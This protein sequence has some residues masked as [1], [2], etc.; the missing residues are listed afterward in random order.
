MF[1]KRYEHLA[2]LDPPYLMHIP[3]PNDIQVEDFRQLVKNRVQAKVVSV[4]SG[5]VD[6]VPV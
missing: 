1:S 6:G 2:Q 3:V 4:L 5:I